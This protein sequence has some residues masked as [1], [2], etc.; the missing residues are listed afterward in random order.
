MRT[1][2]NCF[3]NEAVH[4][5][6]YNEL[7]ALEVKVMTGY[8]VIRWGE[9]P[10]SEGAAIKALV[11]EKLDDSSL[12]KVENVKYFI[13]ADEKSVNHDS[14]K[15]INDACLV[16]DGRLVIDK[17]FRTQDPRMYVFT[18]SIVS[19]INQILDLGLEV[20]QNIR[21]FIKLIGINPITTRLRSVWR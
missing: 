6:V 7:D 21:V 20:L 3:R 11:L 1:A 2:L 5:K 15:A 17:Y 12:I 10:T 9:Q 14:F 4:K 18:Y 19:N 8:R 16:F 13:Y